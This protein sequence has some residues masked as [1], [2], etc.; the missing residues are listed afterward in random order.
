MFGFIK[1]NNLIDEIQRRDWAGF[2]KVY[3]G[4]GYEIQKYDQIL[5]TNY[6]NAKKIA[7]PVV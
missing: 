3:N 6:A 5:A 7:W 1:A 2:A 4:P